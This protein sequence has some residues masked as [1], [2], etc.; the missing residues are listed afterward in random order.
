[1]VSKV[2]THIHFFNFTILKQ[3]Q[4]AKLTFGAY[5]GLI[6][7]PLNFWQRGENV[8]I[9]D[10]KYCTLFAFC[11]TPLN[12]CLNNSA[13]HSLALVIIIIN[14][15]TETCNTTSAYGMRMYLQSCVKQNLMIEL[16]FSS[17]SKKTSYRKKKQVNEFI[18]RQF[19]LDFLT[20][21]KALL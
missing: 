15:L 7:M 19:C 8:V 10:S 3:Q 9:Q 2:V 1:M 12:Y 13:T 5:K 4:Q 18:T 6:S 14:V 16:T 17:S 21:N 11:G 20:N